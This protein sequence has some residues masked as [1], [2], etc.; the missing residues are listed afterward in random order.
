[1]NVL[2]ISNIYPNHQEMN[3]A[4]FNRQQVAY[5]KTHCDIDVV[6][7]VPWVKIFRFGKVQYN[8]LIENINVYHP[9]Y[10]YIPKLFRCLQG[11]FFYMSIYS[12]VRNLFKKRKYD[13]IYASWLYPDGWAAS[14]FSKKYS[15]PLVIQ[16]LGTDVNRLKHDGI[17][18]KQSLDAINASVKVIC[19]SKDLYNR[20]KNFGVDENKL[21]VVYNGVDKK[22]FYPVDKD[23]ARKSL[24]IVEN[25]KIVLYVGNLKKEKG[26]GE[27]LRAYACL[28]ENKDV[29]KHKLFIIGSG[30]YL[31]NMKKMIKSD[32]SLKDVVFLGRQPLESV[33]IWMN[34]ADVVCLPSYSEGLP[35]VINEALA[36]NKKIIATSVGGI[37]EMMTEKGLLYLVE[38]MNHIELYNK[39]KEVTMGEDN[40]INIPSLNSWE[41]HAREVREIFCYVKENINSYFMPEVTPI[42]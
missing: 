27:L 4:T 17:L 7:P 10:Y 42:K 19:V 3:T 20:L 34:A 30:S 16:V 36:C 31:K 5:L 32:L 24:G 41:D 29:M 18:I 2:F 6:A 22:I 23:A 33:A 40:Y 35:N 26:L 1:M 39:I 12:T 28:N 25:F 9:L 14:L 13:I 11:L 37:P 15:V 38:P 21:A 8:E